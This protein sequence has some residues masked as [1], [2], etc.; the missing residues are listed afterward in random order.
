MIEVLTQCIAGPAL[1]RLDSLVEADG[2]GDG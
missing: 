1:A 2:D